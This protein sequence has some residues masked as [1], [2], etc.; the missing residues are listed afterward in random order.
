MG[1]TAAQA[2]IYT[3]SLRFL[4]TPMYPTSSFSIP[5]QFAIT[6]LFGVSLVL[7][8]HYTTPT[9]WTAEAKQSAAGKPYWTVRWEVGSK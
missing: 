3:H 8:S 5:L 1:G 9:Y 6:D 7:T 4:F 2:Q